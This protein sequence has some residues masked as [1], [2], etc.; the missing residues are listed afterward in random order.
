[1]PLF[2]A[3]KVEKEE[4]QRRLQ[5]SLVVVRID[6]IDVDCIQLEICHQSKIQNIS[7]FDLFHKA[8]ESPEASL[9]LTG[10]GITEVSLDIVVSFA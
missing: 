8:E 5:R 3:R 6:F 1:M 10:C 2:R 7:V 4:S 9:D